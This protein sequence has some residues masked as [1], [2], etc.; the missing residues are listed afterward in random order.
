[1]MGNSDILSLVYE[2]KDQLLNSD[3]YK[4]MKSKEERMFLDKECA[5]LLSCFQQL[6]DEYRE[7]KR[8]EKYGSN[9]EKVQKRLS[10][11]KYQLDENTLVKEYN[12]AYKKMKVALK[13]LE[14]NLFKD[15]IEDKK[16]IEIE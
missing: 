14:R 12:E 1:M 10:E 11:V 9:V 7:A 2:L 3:L 8:F 5:R 16:E 4:D 15:I 6:K 13:D